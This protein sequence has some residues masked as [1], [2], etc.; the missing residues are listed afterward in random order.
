MRFN[1]IYRSLRHHG[2]RDG[3]RSFG[4]WRLLAA[5]LALMGAG[6]LP[7]ADLGASLKIGTPGFGGDVTV[8][9]H[10]K[11]NLRAGLNYF[12][13]RF[14]PDAYMRNDHHITVDVRLTSLPVLIDWHPFETSFRFSA[15]LAWN[16]NRFSA[17]AE[18]GDELDFNDRS[19]VVE[20]FYGEMTFLRM[21]P[22]IGIGYGNALQEDGRWTVSLD[23]GVFYH[24]APQIDARATAMHPL[25]QPSLDADL[26]REVDDLENNLAFFMFYPVVSLGFSYRF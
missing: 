24:G 26:A 17:R 9:I 22:Y 1:P 3:K 11:V 19:Y 12:T 7:A 16:N 6:R 8:G 23:V 4:R 10:D 14:S 18:P 25:L 2:R 13:L 5:I 21:T 20:D 15:G